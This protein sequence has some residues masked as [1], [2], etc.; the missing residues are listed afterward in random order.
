MGTTDQTLLDQLKL[1]GRE[2]ARR[3]EY[4]NFTDKDCQS[5]IGLREIVAESIDEIVE[6]F[7]RHITPFN[8]M[9]RLIGDADT[10]QK[11]KN[12]QRIYILSLFDGQYDEDYVHSRL[13]VGVVHKRIGVAPKYYVS[14]VFHLGNILRDTIAG[15]TPDSCQTCIADLAAIEKILMFDLSLIFDT[16]IHSLMD[17]VRRSRE[18]LENYTESLEEIISERTQLLKEQAR[19]DGLT[20]LLNQYY[21]Y[22]EL[23]RELS[24]SQ[25]RGHSTTLI[26]FD[27]DGF[28]K[29][30][31]TKGHRAGDKVLVDVAQ[32]MR[33]S[34][35]QGEILARYG[36]DEFCIIM[37]ECTI[38]D[39]RSLCERLCR[40]IEKHTQGMGISCSMGI[41]MSTV[42][43]F[44]DASTLVKK[45]DEAMYAAKQEPGF[46]IKLAS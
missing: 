22:E 28:K 36:G 12:H 33:E 31:D 30:N 17:E 42:D 20:G 24:R 4:F 18:E 37:P 23:R 35:R 10:L 16:Y 27:L 45:A 14:A 43:H 11:L 34:I 3:K 2:I 46:C 25:R 6:E 44:L 38:D 9:D 13:R 26:Y 40:L 41:A 21:F 32:A 1:T 5:L 7:Y 29:L 39:A 8:E 15:R 19:H